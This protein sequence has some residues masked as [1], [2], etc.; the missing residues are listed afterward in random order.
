MDRHCQN[1]MAIAEYLNEH[2]KVKTVNYP[3]LP[4]NPNHAIAKKQMSQFG[5]MLSFE[6]EGD[7]SNAKK[8]M[9]AC[10][11]CTIAATLGNVDTLLLHPASSSHLNVAKE[12]RESSGIADGLIR[13][14][15]GIEN[16]DDLIQD[17]KQAIRKA[18][19]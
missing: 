15:V 17:I 13:V 16:K 10:N 14:S 9:N 19:V 18:Y 6:L 12:I 1:A 11:L 2:P 5:A 8:F 7:I 4:A 3:G